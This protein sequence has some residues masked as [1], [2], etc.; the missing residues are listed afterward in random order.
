MSITVKNKPVDVPVEIVKTS[1]DGV[2][3]GIQFKVEQYEEDGIG[4]WT[5]GTY[6]TDQDGKL[7]T[8][9][10]PVGTE[11]RITEIVP[12]GYICRSDNPQIITVAAAENQVHFENERLGSIRIHKVNEKGQALSGVVFRLDYSLDDGVTWSPVQA[13]AEDDPAQPGTCTNAAVT[14]GL[15]TTDANG[16]AEYT[17]LCIT[18]EDGAIRYRLTEV[19]SR[20]GYN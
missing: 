20:E 7:L 13:R 9:D 8:P 16:W 5:R 6:T 12:E 1:S 2:V 17:G 4:W 18:T 10:I 14:D 11:L 15:L 19:E 3:E